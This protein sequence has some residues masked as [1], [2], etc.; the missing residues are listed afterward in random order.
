MTEMSNMLSQD[1]Q[2]VC[3][4]GQG[5]CTTRPCFRKYLPLIILLAVLLL[6][7][8]VRFLF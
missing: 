8:A 5:T 3:S 7:I 1:A 6:F 4:E 2:A